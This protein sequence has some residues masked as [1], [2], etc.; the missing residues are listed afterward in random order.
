MEI[1]SLQRIMKGRKGEGTGGHI[2][3][4]FPLSLPPDLP[5]L[6]RLELRSS[7]VQ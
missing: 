7:A 2:N 6:S 5:A 3:P 1:N 4:A